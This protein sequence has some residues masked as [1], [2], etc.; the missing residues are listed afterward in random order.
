VNKPYEVRPNTGSL[1]KNEDKGEPRTVT[2]S[3]GD[4]YVI[5]DADYKGSGMIGDTE[6]WIDARLKTAK[7]GKKYLALKFNPKKVQ[8]KAAAPAKG[9]TED[10][11]ATADL[12]DPLGF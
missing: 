8:Q 5:E 1:F 7:S 12:N 3:T 10:N 4:S 9:L 6:Y 2:S 11:W